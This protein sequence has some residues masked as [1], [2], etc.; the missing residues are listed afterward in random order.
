MEK[1]I[2]LNKLVFENK[3]IGYRINIINNIFKNYSF[4]ISVD[5]VKQFLKMVGN[6]EIKKGVI[7]PVTKLN[8][9]YVTDDGD[10][11]IEIKNK[12]QA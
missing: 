8:G 12:A 3:M 1:F 2:R 11:V 4:D 5:R 6:V 9:S 7:I 10:N